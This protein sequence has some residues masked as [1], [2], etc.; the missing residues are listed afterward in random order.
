MIASNPELTPAQLAY[1][2]QI[3]AQA[4]TILR[5]F[6]TPIDDRY[7][8]CKIIEPDF[9]REAGHNIAEWFRRCG[10]PAVSADVTVDDGELHAV[11]H[12]R[13]PDGFG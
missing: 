5:R 11:V 7:S 2:D 9:E 12:I 4:E 3:T 13:L 1:K 6:I 8:A 10:C